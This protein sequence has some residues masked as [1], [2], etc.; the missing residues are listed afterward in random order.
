[1]FTLI[2]VETNVFGR[3]NVMKIVKEESGIKFLAR[4]LARMPENQTVMLV[5]R[6]A[7]LRVYDKVAYVERARLTQPAESPSRPRT[8]TDAKL[9]M[10]W[11]RR[12]STSRSDRRGILLLWV[13]NASIDSCLAREHTRAFDLTS[14]RDR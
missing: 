2:I 4:L 9:Y 14:A 6:E 10:S 7:K 12:G 13:S 8:W 1:M 3:D 11:K 5:A